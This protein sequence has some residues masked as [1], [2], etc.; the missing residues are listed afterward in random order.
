MLTMTM[1]DTMEHS[2]T[3]ANLGLI[4]R[5]YRDASDY[6]AIAQVLHD[7]R[8]GDGLEEAHTASDIANLFNVAR[9]LEPERDILLVESSS[10]VGAYAVA[11]WWEERDNNFV[12]GIL[13]HVVPEW[14]YQGVETELLARCQAR[15]MELLRKHSQDGVNWFH[16][17]V[18][19]EQTWMIELLKANG[20]TPERYFYDMVRPDLENIPNED[21]PAGLEV[22][23]VKRE[24][25]HQIWEAAVEAFAEHWGEQMHSENDF[26]NFMKMPNLDSS[27]WQIA[28]DGDQV[29][30]M[31]LNYW[32]PIENVNYNRKRGYTEDISVRKPWRGRG[33]AKALI[34]RSLKMF[35]EMGFESTALGVDSENATGALHLYERLGYRTVRTTIAYRK[36][37][38]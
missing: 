27:L 25:Y 17:Y 6:E 3:L 14:R 16:F 34:V 7:S 18:P 22:R 31:V 21:L 13:L 26:D 28:W 38:E 15:S 32:N 29:A 10:R 8:T 30:G 2:P 20:Y 23:P 1:N 37:I 11:R 33:L 36:R 35:R 5:N 12:H 4:L 9:D 24:Q 19:V